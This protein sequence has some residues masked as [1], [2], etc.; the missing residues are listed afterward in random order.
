MP[1]EPPTHREDGLRRILSMSWAYRI[2]GTLIGGTRATSRLVRQRARPFSGC[3]ILELGCGPGGLL[4]HLPDQT[5]EYCGI[6]M[7]PAY[8][9]T[10]RRRWAARPNCTFIREEIECT[11]APEPGY[12]DIV[13]AISVLHHLNDRDADRVFEIACD[14]LKP[15]GRLIT[16]D[17]VY[18]ESQNRLARW[19]ISHDRGMAVRTVK[20]YEGVARRRF[21][22]VQ[23]AVLHNTLFVPYTIFTMTCIKD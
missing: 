21:G 9:E 7:N 20:E 15:G 4:S 12:F 19:L 13:L 18:V 17:G 2:F 16:Y 11:A 3:R 22:D 6:D 10:A 8:I 1:R 14:G 23:G 5:V